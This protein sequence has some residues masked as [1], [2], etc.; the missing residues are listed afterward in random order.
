MEITLTM[1]YRDERQQRAGG[2][3]GVRRRVGE[4]GHDGGDRGGVGG[5]RGNV[6]GGIVNRKYIC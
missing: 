2:G 4:D 5:R 3:R 6:P 1:L